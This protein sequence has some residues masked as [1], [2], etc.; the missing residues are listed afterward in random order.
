MGLGPLFLLMEDWSHAEIMFC[1][2]EGVF[3]LSELDVGSPQGFGIG[4]F[5]VGAEDIAAPGF[6]RPLV[7]L[8]VL[9][10][11]ERDATVSSFI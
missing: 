5:P 3:D 9:L 10:D 4:L 11:V 6:P 8:F 2:T 7:A 1:G